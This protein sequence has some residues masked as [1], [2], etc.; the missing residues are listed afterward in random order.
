MTLSVSAF[1]WLVSIATVVTTLSPLL[2]I[3]LFIRDLR[4]GT[5]W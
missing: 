2:L 3:G 4:R 5:L 1:T